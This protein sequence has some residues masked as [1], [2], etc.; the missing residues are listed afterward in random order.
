MVK[1]N[2]TYYKASKLA[3]IKGNMGTSVRPSLNVKTN[4]VSG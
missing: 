4:I 2:N 3:D 1:V